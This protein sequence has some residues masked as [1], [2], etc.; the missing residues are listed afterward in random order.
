MAI[1]TLKLRTRVS[2]WVRPALA[3]AFVLAVLADRWIDAIV[4][5]GIKVETDPA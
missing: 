5:R 3:V 1:V 2:W 4:D